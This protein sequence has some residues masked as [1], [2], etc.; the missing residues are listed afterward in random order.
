MEGVVGDVVG[1]AVV[2]EVEHI[3]EVAVGPMDMDMDIHIRILAYI[4]KILV[5]IIKILL[6][7]L[8]YMS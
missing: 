1:T 4:I 6:L 8:M 5:Y 3:G 2:I 7:N